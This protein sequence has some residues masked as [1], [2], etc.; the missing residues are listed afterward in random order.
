MWGPQ[1]SRSQGPCTGKRRACISH[2]IL[3]RLPYINFISPS[4]FCTTAI[5]YSKTHYWY[6]GVS[7]CSY[8]ELQFGCPSEC[9][10]M[11]DD[12]IQEQSRKIAKC[13]EV[14][15]LATPF[16]DSS[17]VA[18]SRHTWDSEWTWYSLESVGSLH[19]CQYLFQA[20]SNLLPLLSIPQFNIN[21]LLTFIRPASA[22]TICCSKSPPCYQKWYL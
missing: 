12:Q 10:V 21:M 4:K 7:C 2:L 14:Q 15:A 19:C 22:I 9:C 1:A 5:S 13:W 17:S 3:N 18:V 11:Y 16:V 20:Q 8:F 6:L